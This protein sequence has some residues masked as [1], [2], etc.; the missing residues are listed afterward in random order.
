MKLHKTLLISNT[1]ILILLFGKNK[2]CATIVNPVKLIQ[3]NLMCQYVEDQPLL[4]LLNWL[5]GFHVLLLRDM[6]K[7]YL[8]L[9][10]VYLNCFNQLIARV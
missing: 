5:F 4:I 7:D 8:N 2:I 6:Y 9:H 10:R 1:F 3:F